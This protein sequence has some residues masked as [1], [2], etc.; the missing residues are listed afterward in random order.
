MQANA[1]SIDAAV[2]RWAGAQGEFRFHHEVVIVAGQKSFGILNS[3]FHQMV[4]SRGY[5]CNA[6]DLTEEEITEIIVS[7]GNR[8]SYAFYSVAELVMAAKSTPARGVAE[9]ES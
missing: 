1:R 3:E 2:G 7:G 8:K 6:T 4:G 9:V 5:S